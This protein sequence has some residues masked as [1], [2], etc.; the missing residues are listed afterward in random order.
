MVT[1]SA[2]GSVKLFSEHAVV[3][4]RLGV[5]GAFDKRAYAKVSEHNKKTILYLKDFNIQKELTK[6]EIKKIHY[7]LKE[8]MDKEDIEIILKMSKKDVALPHIFILG[9][10]FQKF[11]YYPMKITV[12]SEIPRKS[13]LGSSSAVFTALA[14]AINEKLRLKLKNRQLIRLANEGDK[15]VHGKPSG[16]DVGTCFFGGYIKFK[17][18]EGVKPLQIKTEIPLVVADTGIYKDTGIMV[19]AVK[20]LFH[21]KPE[22]I[23]SL[24]NET[25][26]IALSGLKALKQGDF[27][28][29][30]ELFNQAQESLRKLGVS[31]LKIEELIKIANENGAYGAK[32]TGAG[33]GGCIIAITKQ[34]QLLVKIFNKKGYKAFQTKLGVEGAKIE[35]L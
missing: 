33:R 22:K 11:G 3:Y 29:L 27:Q 9:E 26:K 14:H 23:N 32:L 1:S 6:E 21:K 15:V 18:S 12:K 28:E 5:S 17:R 31:S 13:G 10:I 8:L 25:E 2:P 4:D 19:A 20:K 24:F 34:P 7:P 35:K 30:G 16:I